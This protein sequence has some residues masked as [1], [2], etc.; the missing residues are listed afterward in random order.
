[1]SDNL[2]FL[3]E[4]PNHKLPKELVDGDRVQIIGGPSNAPEYDGK[5]GHVI[6]YPYNATGVLAKDAGY[7]WV[8][9]DHRE[10]G[11]TFWFKNVRHIPDE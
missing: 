5:R 10:R 6:G 3:L 2:N 8:K 11:R 1:M 9:F 7:V 4:D